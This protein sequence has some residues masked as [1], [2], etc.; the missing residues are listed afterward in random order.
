LNSF[1]DPFVDGIG[2]IEYSQNAN[3]FVVSGYTDFSVWTKNE[4]GTFQVFS[5]SI[6]GK[7]RKEIQNAY[8]INAVFY[9][10]T[11]VLTTD[12]MGWTGMYTQ[13]FN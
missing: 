1:Q 13:K 11:T 3:S 2:S 12:S 9:D 5:H 10:D 6:Q 8:T 7:S 4:L